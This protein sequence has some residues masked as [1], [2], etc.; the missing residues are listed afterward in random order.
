MFP[1]CGSS[2]T[3]INPLLE[4]LRPIE[5]RVHVTVLARVSAPHIYINTTY[6]VVT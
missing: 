5:L 6:I 2:R 3:A 4:N 1:D